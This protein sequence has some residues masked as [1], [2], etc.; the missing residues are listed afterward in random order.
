MGILKGWE[1][2]EIGAIYG[3]KQSMAKKGELK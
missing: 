2:G 1:T 3:T